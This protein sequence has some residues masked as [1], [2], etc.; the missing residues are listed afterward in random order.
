ML[1]SAYEECLCYELQL[2]GLAFR[3][4]VELPLI[5]KGITLDC[6]YRIDV[7][8]ENAV[9][10]ELKCVEKLLPIHES[11]L[12]TYL[13]LSRTKIGLLLNFNVPVMRDGIVRRIL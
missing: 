3:R 5:Y 13:R 2:R 11:Q 9:L 10:L 1:E 8:V 12:L 7:M 4:Q 6:G